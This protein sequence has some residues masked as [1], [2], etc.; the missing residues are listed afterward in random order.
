MNQEK[1]TGISGMKIIEEL[2]AGPICKTYNLEISRL[3]QFCHKKDIEILI[4]G[5][6]NNLLTEKNR[7]TTI[8]LKDMTELF[9]YFKLGIV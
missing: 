2:D 7:Y 9:N 5:S 8:E 3:I 1:E 6:G 4:G